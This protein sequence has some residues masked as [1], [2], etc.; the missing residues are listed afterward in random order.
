MRGDAGV[1]KRDRLRTCWLSAYGGSNPP[2]HMLGPKVP[3]GGLGTEG[4]EVGI[5]L[6]TY[7]HKND[8]V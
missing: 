3:V 4:S 7:I 6:S 8:A 2:L 5:L 1:V